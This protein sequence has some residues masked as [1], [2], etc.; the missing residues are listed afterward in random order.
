V[1]ITPSATPTSPANKPPSAAAEPKGKEGE[2]PRESLGKA[3]APAQD[4]LAEAALLADKSSSQL[5]VWMFSFL[6]PVRR[7]AVIACT[8]LICWIGV[9]ILTTRQMGQA[10]DQMKLIHFK[11]SAPPVGFWQWISSPADADARSLRGSILALSGLV[12]LNA[13]LRYLRETANTRLSMTMVYYLREAVYDKIQRVGFAFHDRV[14]TGQLINRA[15]T[16]LQNVRAFIQT[17]LLVTLEIALIT[18]G[19]I[20][21]IF[22][23]NPWLALVAAMPLPIWTWY[24]LRFGKKVQPASKAVMEAEDKNVSIL[25]ENIAG[26][27]VVKAFAS[28]RQEIEKYHTTCDTYFDKVRARIKLYAN[29][30]PVIRTI[31]TVSHL[32]LYLLAGFFIITGYSLLGRKMEVGDFLV[33]GTAMGAILQRL[34]QV[35]VISEQYQ[36]AIVSSKRLYE[37]LHAPPTVAVKEGAAPLPPG[38][39]TVR[40]DGVTFGYDPARPVIKDVTFDV[41]GGRVVAIVGPTGAGKTTL[42]NLIARFYDPQRGRILIDGVDIR[43]LALDTLR[44]EVAF[45]FQE[46]H[47][48]SDSIEANVAY[49]KPHVKGGAVEAAVRLAQAHDFVQEMPKGYDTVLAERGASLSGGQKQRLAIARAILSD[50][51]ILVLDDATAAIDPETEELIRRGMRHVM[52]ERTTF[53]IAHR[54]SSVKSADLVLVLE[55]GRLTQAGTH[56]QL[57]RQDGHYREI[58]AAQLQGYDAADGE[59]NPS[60][61]KRMRDERHVADAAVAAQENQ[62]SV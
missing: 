20:I 53:L 33:L 6:R 30:T 55:E 57:M 16:D 14:S 15:L 62:G 50:P 43:D 58:A 39:G 26:V 13:V 35:A 4:A 45:V 25:T 40:F 17:A 51:R 3:Q 27:H 56:E 22:T 49:G 46:T 29:F 34:Q 31:A 44:A 11:P 23:L 10:V 7:I 48:F 12:L 9:D 24:I 47:L 41:P 18:G 32:S 61:I 52:R 2:S 1:S 42:V 38:P 28:Q 36:N 54:I 19:Y 8:V 60:H 21:L 59:E 37:V 5:I